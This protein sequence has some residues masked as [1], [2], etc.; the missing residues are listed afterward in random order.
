MGC[1]DINTVKPF[2]DKCK[3]DVDELVSVN[4]YHDNKIIFIAYCHGEREEVKMDRMDV[5]NINPKE[6]R[7]G[8]AFKQQLGLGIK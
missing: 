2:C 5:D 3:K 6:I 7:Q 4:S 1:F 8:I